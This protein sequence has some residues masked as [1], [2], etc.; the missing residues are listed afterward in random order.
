MEVSVR[1]MCIRREFPTSDNR[2]IVPYPKNVRII[3]LKSIFTISSVLFKIEFK[4]KFDRLINMAPLSDF[5]LETLVVFLFLYCF[6]VLIFLF[7]DIWIVRTS[8][9]VSATSLVPALIRSSE[10]YFKGVTQPEIQAEVFFMY[11][12]YLFVINT[13]HVP[14]CTKRAVGELF[15]INTLSLQ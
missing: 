1:I 14:E 10:K 7:F 15:S 6:L 8:E 4:K 13:S 11:F 2:N 5:T 3:K 9:S 12:W